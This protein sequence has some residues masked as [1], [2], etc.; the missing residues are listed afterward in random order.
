MGPARPKL[1]ISTW[2]DSVG[3]LRVPP[4]AG[5]ASASSQP[6]HHGGVTSSETPLVG[7]AVRKLV[8]MATSFF[9]QQS[10]RQTSGALPDTGPE[11]WP[12]SLGLQRAGHYL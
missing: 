5:E 10:D 8:P 3:R 4:P 9:T 6:E 1:L 11:W 12:K 2:R 7:M